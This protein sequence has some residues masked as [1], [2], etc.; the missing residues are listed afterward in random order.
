[1]AKKFF[2]KGWLSLSFVRIGDATVALHFGFSFKGIFYYYLP[3]YNPDFEKYSI[4][5]VLLL[6]LLRQSFIS[7]L[8]KFDFM[9]GEEAYKREWNCEVEPLY[10]LTITPKGIKG[11]LARQF[12]HRAN[13]TAKKIFNKKW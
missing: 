2:R 9:L 7:A 12:F 4:G 5:R 8:K 6:D 13:L 1:V 3:G 11:C 10:F